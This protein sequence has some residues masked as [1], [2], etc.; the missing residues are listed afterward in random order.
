MDNVT[1]ELCER[2][3]E[4]GCGGVESYKLFWNKIMPIIQWDN[5]RAFHWSYLYFN[6]RMTLNGVPLR[7][8]DN[9]GFF[10]VVCNTT[11]YSHFDGLLTCKT[12]HS[13]WLAQ[14]QTLD[15]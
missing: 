15:F 4:I 12:R 8:N 6:I 1:S 2:T 14:L 13:C 3:F 10:M 5:L 11:F 7:N 9:M